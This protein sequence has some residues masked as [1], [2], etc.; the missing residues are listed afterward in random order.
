MAKRFRL[1]LLIEHAA[2]LSFDEGSCI[3][4]I[5]QWLGVLL[6][7]EIE[8]RDDVAL[9]RRLQEANLEFANASYPRIHKDPARRLDMARVNSLF[10]LD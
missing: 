1:T 4:S 6:S 7:I 8:R 9:V 3:W 5:H 10:S 2:E